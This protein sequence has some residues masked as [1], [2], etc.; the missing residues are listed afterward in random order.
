MSTLRHESSLSLTGLSRAHIRQLV[1]IALGVPPPTQKD[2]GASQ[3]NDKN[4]RVDPDFQP[5]VAIN[6]QKYSPLPSREATKLARKLLI[7]FALTNSP[8]SLLCALP[9]YPL[10][11]NLSDIRGRVDG[12]GLLYDG[13]D[14]F[15]AK[16]AQCVGTA[17]NVWELLKPG[18]VKWE[19]YASNGVANMAKG[20]RRSARVKEEFTDDFLDG[21]EPA[22]VG[23]EAWSVL[24]WLILV[25]DKDER[26]TVEDGQRTFISQPLIAW[27][28]NCFFSLLLSTAAINNTVYTEQGSSMG[29]SGRT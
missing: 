8:A 17:T 2:T 14:S 6:Q 22:A 5:P 25:F 24:D 15:I 21:K 13:E 23:E 27:L 10:D 18:F 16:V 1:C 20:K 9:R 26:R 28:N 3:K 29:C 11:S 4:K 7:S 19:D 12:E